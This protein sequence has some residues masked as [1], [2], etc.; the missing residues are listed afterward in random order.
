MGGERKTT[1]RRGR[2]GTI[3][4]PLS[5]LSPATQTKN[6]FVEKR[7]RRQQTKKLGAHLHSP[8]QTKLHS[9]LGDIGNLVA[10]LAR[11]NVSQA[12]KARAQEVSKGL[13]ERGKGVSKSIRASRAASLFFLRRK[14]RGRASSERGRGGAATAVWRGSIKRGGALLLGGALLCL[15]LP[16]LEA[17]KSSLPA[18]G[19]EGRGGK[20]RR[21][22]GRGRSMERL[23][24]SILAVGGTLRLSPPLPASFRQQLLRRQRFCGSA[25]HLA[26]ESSGVCLLWNSN[27]S[28]RKLLDLARRRFRML[29]FFNLPSFLARKKNKNFLSCSSAASSP[30]APRPRPA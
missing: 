17:Q 19:A 18:A 20:E 3:R 8:L 5:A 7:R 6:G 4:P 9:A 10:P 1:S 14:K 23:P 29:T 21:A 11:V 15:P 12:E 25:S 24:L 27:A 16:L 26:L 13:S 30:A 2:R 22:Q 28:K